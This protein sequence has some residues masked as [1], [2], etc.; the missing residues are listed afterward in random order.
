MPCRAK[1]DWAT[2]AELGEIPLVAFGL[3]LLQ[4]LAHYGKLECKSATEERAEDGNL[5]GVA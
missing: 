1:Q 3:S 5:E 4:A 2:F